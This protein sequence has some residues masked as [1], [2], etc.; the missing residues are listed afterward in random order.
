M[1]EEI[2]RY[3]TDYLQE[4]GYAPSVRE[5]AEGVGLKSPSSVHRYLVEMIDEG[6]LET[7]AEAGTPRAIRV[8]GWKYVKE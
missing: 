8:R 1:R 4:H 3:I 7:D 6:I 2:L 5:I